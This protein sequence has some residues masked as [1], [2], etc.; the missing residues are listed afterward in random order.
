VQLN[1]PGLVMYRLVQNVVEELAWGYRP[2]LDASVTNT[3]VISR[4]CA[5]QSPLVPG[6]VY[7][8]W[9]WAVDNYGKP[10]QLALVNVTIPGP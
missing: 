3:E 4:D 7:G 9:Y 10:N 8:L 2:V 5:T 1:K 6:V